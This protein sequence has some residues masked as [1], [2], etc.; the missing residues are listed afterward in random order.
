MGGGPLLGGIQSRCPSTTIYMAAHPR[1]VGPG[2]AGRSEPAAGRGARA[3]PSS[4]HAI[5]QRELKS[6]RGADSDEEL[7]TR[8]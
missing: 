1:P 6:H 8:T 7:L 2:A 5:P 4:K 3:A